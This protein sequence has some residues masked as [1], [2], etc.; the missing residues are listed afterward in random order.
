MDQPSIQSF[1]SREVPSSIQ[2]PST[3]KNSLP[4][5]TSTNLSSTIVPNYHHASIPGDGFTSDEVSA[6]LHPTFDSSDVD[7]GVIQQPGLNPWNPGVEYKDVDI[8]EL[9]PGP[10]R[11]VFLGRVVN[12]GEMVWSRGS[13]GWKGGMKPKG[14]LRL[15]VR[16]EGGIV[17]VSL[18]SLRYLSFS[19]ILSRFLTIFFFEGKVGLYEVVSIRQRTT[20]IPDEVTASCYSQ[21]EGGKEVYP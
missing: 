2:L 21:R 7:D 3:S 1:Y 13:D 9:R 16:D 6:A 4:S 14:Y 11:V 15:A 5:A 17:G 18:S 8:G 19:W 10:G 12:L 20:Y